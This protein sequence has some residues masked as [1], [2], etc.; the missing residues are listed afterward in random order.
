MHNTEPNILPF[1]NQKKGAKV[2]ADICSYMRRIVP[3]P[4]KGRTRSQ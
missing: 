2:H 1:I 3:T 4:P